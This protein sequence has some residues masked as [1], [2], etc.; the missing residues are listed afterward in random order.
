[1]ATQKFLRLSAADRTYDGES[2]YNPDFDTVERVIMVRVGL[3]SFS[4]V[5]PLT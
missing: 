3:G 2:R 5:K 4:V 1:M